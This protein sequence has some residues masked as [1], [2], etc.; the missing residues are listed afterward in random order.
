MSVETNGRMGLSSF[1][2]AFYE[3][4]YL[5]KKLKLN[6]MIGGEMIVVDKQ[7]FNIIN[8]DPDDGDERTEI[9]ING[10]DSRKCLLGLIY[11]NETSLILQGF[12]YSQTC[13]TDKQMETGKGTKAMFN[14]LKKYVKKYY[15]KVNKIV[16]EDSSIFR[17]LY[18]E[19]TINFNLYSYYMLKY[20]KPYYMKNFEFKFSDEKQLNLY[21]KNL[22]F[23]NQQLIINKYILNRYANYM[24][25]RYNK[26][27]SNKLVK[28]NEIVT[29]KDLK[30]I[31]KM[32]NLNCLYLFGLVDYYLSHELV[33]LNK[34]RFYVQHA[35]F[36]LD[37]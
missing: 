8:F 18:E 26:I 28:F 7:E 27:S 33:L 2:K 6:K 5:Q 4:K 29:D 32:K 34:E 22:S 12:G 30:D 9:I 14:A 35:C 17:C 19:Q 13:T 23:I 36:E 37:I 10:D 3:T 1:G 11:P 21:I 16:L 24:D 31:V 25:E 20:G 15:P